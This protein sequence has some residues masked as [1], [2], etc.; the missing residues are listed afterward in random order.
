MCRY[1]EKST[2]PDNKKR[3]KRS[4]SS[5]IFFVSNYGNVRRSG[6]RIGKNING[7][8]SNKRIQNL[9]RETMAGA[10]SD[11]PSMARMTNNIQLNGSPFFAANGMANGT[12]SEFDSAIGH[13]AIQLHHQKSLVNGIPSEVNDNDPGT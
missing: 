12:D 11:D 1:N 10:I 4:L 9:N 3:H 7:I 6:E 2:V 5:P 8:F 13:S